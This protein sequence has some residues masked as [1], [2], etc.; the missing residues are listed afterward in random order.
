MDLKQYI[1]KFYVCWMDSLMD[2]RLMNQ[3]AICNLRIHIFLEK[4]FFVECRFIC[5][6]D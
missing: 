4:F 5:L 6:G 2:G 1:V 3:I